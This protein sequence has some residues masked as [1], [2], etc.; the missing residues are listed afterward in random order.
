MSLI[1]GFFNCVPTWR[2]PATDALLEAERP[3]LLLFRCP[4]CTEVHGPTVGAAAGGGERWTWNGSYDKPV[5]SPSLLVRWTTLSKEA[6]ARN[7]AFFKK[8]G[9]NMTDAELPYDVNHVCHSFI[10]CNGAQPGQIIFLNDSTH[11]LAGK[12]VDMVPY[13][14]GN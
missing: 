3:M 7:D 8:H 14:L 10:G 2:G 13:H 11:P 4:G 6:R 1:R 9:R 5:F 12:T